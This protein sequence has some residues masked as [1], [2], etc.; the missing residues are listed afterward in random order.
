MT[1]WMSLVKGGGEEEGFMGRI[2]F[3]PAI[4]KFGSNY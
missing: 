3:H 4:I 1:H 2:L